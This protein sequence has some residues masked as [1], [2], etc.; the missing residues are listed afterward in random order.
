MG[1]IAI[2]PLTCISYCG[3]G[4]LNGPGAS[5]LSPTA[6][7]QAQGQA[8]V[9]AWRGVSQTQCYT[10]FGDV[11]DGQYGWGTNQQANQQVWAG[12]YG[13]LSD[14][15]GTLGLYVGH[16]SDWNAIMGSGYQLQSGVWVWSRDN[17]LLNCSTDTNHS[18]LPGNRPGAFPSQPP[19]GGV[20][21]F[22]QDRLRVTPDR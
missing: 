5:T 3:V 11:E 21:P 6:W 17:N 10:I 19:I 2:R 9:T 16:Q 18:P 22:S 12:F 15:F 14:Y 8:A 7:G 20:S 4:E 13:V 1:V